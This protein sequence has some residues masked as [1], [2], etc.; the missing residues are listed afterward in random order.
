MGA[1]DDWREV[2]MQH[3]RASTRI[4][5]KPHRTAVIVIVNINFYLNSA[6]VSTP[7]LLALSLPH[8]YLWL[9]YP[10]PH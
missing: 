10:V 5:S 8:R 9:R 2:G 7:G 3:P 6:F 1:V 4:E